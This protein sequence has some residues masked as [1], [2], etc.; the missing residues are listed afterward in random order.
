M[1]PV[2]R[3]PIP[4]GLAEEGGE[5]QAQGRLRGALRLHICKREAS[6]HPP[7]CEISS[8]YMFWCRYGNAEVR[9]SICSVIMQRVVGM[10]HVGREDQQHAHAYA[11]EKRRAL[12]VNVCPL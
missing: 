10:T 6:F 4:A 1:H 12:D 2:H 3:A 11:L 8:I 9:Y 5:A 7:M